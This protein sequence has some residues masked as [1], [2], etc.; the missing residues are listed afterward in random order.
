MSTPLRRPRAVKRLSIWLTFDKS[1]DPIADSLR[2]AVQGLSWMHDGPGFEPHV[3]ILTIEP[4]LARDADGAADVEPPPTVDA[5]D[6]ADDPAAAA[7]SRRRARAAIP[8]DVWRA[9][10]FAC[11]QLACAVQPLALRLGAIVGGETWNEALFVRL[12]GGEVGR[13]SGSLS[14][15]SPSC[16]RDLHRRGR[17][18]RKRS[19]KGG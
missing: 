12:L 9:L 2:C 3:T 11:G 13:A 19:R 8:A 18:W 14:L 15:L 17:A 1:N 6:A 5:A 10:V 16:V 7:L 4:P